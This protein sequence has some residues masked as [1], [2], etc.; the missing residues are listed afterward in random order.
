M[1]PHDYILEVHKILVDE[2]ERA[3]ALL[4]NSTKPKMLETILEVLLTNNAKALA[5]SPGA[6]IA[7]M[8]KNDRKD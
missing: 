5:D 3:N 4:D 7:S 8:F 1:S 6:G 2:E